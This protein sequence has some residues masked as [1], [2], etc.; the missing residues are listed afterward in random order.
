[1]YIDRASL[2][3]RDRI[4]GFHLNLYKTYSII[5]SLQMRA[6]SMDNFKRQIFPVCKPDAVDLVNPEPG[7][8]VVHLG[9][10]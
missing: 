3:K 10:G 4:M 9:L 6:T 5:N 2:S 7:G 1:M 8:S